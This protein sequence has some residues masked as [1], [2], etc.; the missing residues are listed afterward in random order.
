MDRVMSPLTGRQARER[1]Y[2]DEYVKRTA[3]NE[4][5]LEAIGGQ[6][7]RPWNPYWYLTHFV[8]SLFRGA[9]Q[10]L[11]DFGCGPGT[12]AVLFARIG[13]EVWGFDVSPANIETARS[14]AAS[15]GVADRTH[16]CE[17]IAERL[18]YPPES[19]D[20]VAGID[21][22]HH[23]EIGLAIEEC[24]RVLK[25]GGVAVFK[26]PIEAPVFDRVRNSRFG[27]AL[28]SKWASF[29]SH[30]TEDERKLSREDVCYIKRRYQA[31][32]RRFR[33]MSRLEA[34]V[35]ERAFK[36]RSGSSMLEMFDYA[37]LRVL[38]PLGTFA[39]TTV[40]IWRKI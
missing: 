38:P 16:F 35:G 17:G 28:K 25:P 26:E 4:I 33:F 6:E 20:V 12:Y 34:L 5:A 15:Y 24:M 21:I 30:I 13:Y 7:Q 39:G 29:E 37:L 23:V 2:Y 10:R 36:T 18:D 14:I 22:L 3:P 27:R 31:D 40:L 11:L 9:D 8:S 19:F 32:D 1:Q